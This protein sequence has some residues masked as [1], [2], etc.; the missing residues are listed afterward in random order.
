MTVVPGFLRLIVVLG[1]LQGGAWTHVEAAPEYED[2]TLPAGIAAGLTHDKPAGGVGVADFDR[3]GYPDLL[4]TGYFEPNRLFFNNGNETF[5]EREPFATQLATGGSRCTAVA[6]ADY[7][8]DGWPDA[9]LICNGDNLLLRNAGPAGFVDTTTAPVNHP[10][11]SENAVWAD[12]N[13][14]GNLDLVVAA[15]PRTDNPDPADP[16][17]YDRILLGDGAGTFVDIAGGF[18]WSVPM[19]TTL[20]LIAADF[21]LDGWM[22]LYFVNDRHDG[23]VLLRNAGPGC[24]GWCFE[25]VSIVTGA[26]RAAYSMGVSVADYDRDGDWDVYYSSMDEMVLLRNDRNGPGLPVFVEATDAAGV[27]SPWIGWGVQFIDADNDS[28]EDLFLGISGPTGN[29]EDQLFHQQ[30]D[31]TFVAVGPG[32]GLHQI[33]A[34]EAAG[35]LDLDRDG[36]PDLALGHSNDAYG[37]YRNTTSGSG[38]WVGFMLEGGG[39]VNRD[40]IGARVT[41]ETPD[42]VRQVRERRAGESRNA[43]N[44]EILLFGLGTQTEFE[45]TIRWP[46]GVVE[47]LVGMD[48]D[49]YHHRAHPAID[50]VFEDNFT[51]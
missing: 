2:I 37:L 1:L 22:D 16:T 5:S 51:P 50:M 8:N 32:S 21:D 25:D 48:I 36:L 26:D 27:N 14:D 11:R 43:T 39:A 49:R 17:N 18:E 45:A 4:L 23:N 6:A 47:T 24:E 40:A 15:H 9:Y 19:G 41:V 31:A 46:D 44:D 3:N 33:R 10:E 35:W 13:L 12:F 28:R 38:N 30:D 20:G 29:N 34:T 42:G 7:D